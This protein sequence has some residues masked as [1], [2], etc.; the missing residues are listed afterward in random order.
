MSIGIVLIIGS[1][2]VFIVAFVAVLWKAYDEHVLAGK[3]YKIERYRDGERTV[4]WVEED[5]IEAG[6]RVIEGPEL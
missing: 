4:M 6:D 2:V 1:I 5:E 3:P